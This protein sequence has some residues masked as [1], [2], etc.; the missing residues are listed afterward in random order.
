MCPQAKDRVENDALS[1][2]IRLTRFRTE[3]PEEP[4]LRFGMRCRCGTT[5]R[6]GVQITGVGDD[7]TWDLSQP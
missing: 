1:S 2:Q 3:R 5:Q 7:A 6:K 4:L